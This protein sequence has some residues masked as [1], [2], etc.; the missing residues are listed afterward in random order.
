MLGAG[1]IRVGAA[2]GEL[3]PRDGV[4]R[5]Q[6]LAAKPQARHL[7][8][9]GQAGDLAGGVTGQGEREF[10]ARD[11]AAVVTHPDALDAA[12]LQIDLDIGGAGVEA[13]FE[14]FLQGRGGAF[15]H[16]AGG[17]L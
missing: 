14:N 13:V 3:H 4:D 5:R 9:V 16:L 12:L 15:D 1:V 2:A 10:V 17:D 7:F 8:E 6:R 11:A